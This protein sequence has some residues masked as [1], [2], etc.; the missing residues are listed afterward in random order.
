MVL[1]GPSARKTQGFRCCPSR[2]FRRTETYAATHAT[3]ASRPRMVRSLMMTRRG[4][5]SMRGEGP[6]ILP[7]YRLDIPLA[8]R[9]WANSERATRRYVSDDS[10]HRATSIQTWN[11]IRTQNLC[12]SRQLSRHVNLSISILPLGKMGDK[13]DEKVSRKKPTKATNS[14]SGVSLPNFYASALI[15]TISVAH[16]SHQLSKRHPAILRRKMVQEQV[17]VQ[18]AETLWSQ[19][20]PP[21]NRILGNRRINLPRPMSSFSIAVTLRKRYQ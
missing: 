15:L 19:R 2:S 16:S 12:Q 7:L 14:F 20:L 9:G 1:L 5:G 4:N 17:E 13:A 18:R 6:G 8:R 11:Q 10:V 21:R 3:K